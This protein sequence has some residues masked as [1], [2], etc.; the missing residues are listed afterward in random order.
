MSWRSRE[1]SVCDRLNALQKLLLIN[2]NITFH[3]HNKSFNEIN[4][5]KISEIYWLNT[6]IK[7]R[8]SCEKN[9]KIHAPSHINTHFTA[10]YF[11]IIIIIIIYYLLL[12]LLII[13][14]IGCYRP[15][16]TTPL[17]S[18]FLDLVLRRLNKTAKTDYR[19]LTTVCLSAWHKSASIGRIL[20]KFD[21]WDFLKISWRSSGF[22]NIWKE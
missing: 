5:L 18:C 4:Y 1:T 22:S 20:I 10:F 6:E 17:F 13:T 8:S 21:F 7:F 3:Q 14:F 16:E 12:L 19:F 11:R 15:E 2:V 9:M